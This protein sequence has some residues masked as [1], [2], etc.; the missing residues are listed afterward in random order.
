MKERTLDKIDLKIL[1][2][3]KRMLES[4]LPRSERR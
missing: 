2:L 1:D 4:A 3:I